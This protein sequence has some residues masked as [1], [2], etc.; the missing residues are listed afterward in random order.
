MPKSSFPEAYVNAEFQTPEFREGVE[1]LKH[2]FRKTFLE[3]AIEDARFDNVGT[4]WTAIHELAFEMIEIK[5]GSEQAEV[6]WS[7]LVE[8]SKRLEKVAEEGVA[9]KM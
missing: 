2:I 8:F 4:L 5:I 6:Y 3:A 7:R 1:Y 9:L